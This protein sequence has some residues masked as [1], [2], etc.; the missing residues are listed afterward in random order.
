MIL[1]TVNYIFVIGIHLQFFDKFVRYML[2]DNEGKKNNN[3]SSELPRKKHQVGL[4]ELIGNREKVQFLKHFFIYF[5]VVLFSAFANNSIVTS[6]QW[7][8]VV[9]LGWGIIVL[10]HFVYLYII[11]PRILLYRED[12]S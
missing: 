12:N 1:M 3:S 5:L 4:F 10:I 8:L 11:K 6:Y 7:W 2:A 9:S